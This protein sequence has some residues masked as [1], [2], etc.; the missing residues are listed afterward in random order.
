MN[1]KRPLILSLLVLSSLASAGPR[2]QV[3]F[4]GRPGT[5]PTPIPSPIPNDPWDR[6]DDWGRDNRR[7]R[8]ERIE[9]QVRQYFMGQANL[10][11][12][13]DYYILSQ[14]RFKKISRIEV[15]LSSERGGGQ[16][17]LVLNGRALEADRTIP[18]ELLAHS[19]AV[20]SR[21]SEI[22]RSLRSVVLELRGRFYVEKVTFITNE[23]DHSPIP[24]PFPPQSEILRQSI[25][26]RIQGE[27][28][29]NLFRQ[30]SL[31]EKQ[32]KQVSR[33]TVRAR[34]ARG[35]GEVALLKNVETFGQTQ[36]IGAYSTE[37]SFQLN[38][39]KIGL[40]LQSLR[41]QF[42]GDV[43]I[44][45]VSIEVGEGRVGPGPGP[46]PPMER[47]IEQ[48]V[49]QRLYD[50]SGVEL[51]RLMFVDRRHEERQ[52][53][54]VELVLR[55]AD[56]GTRVKLCTTLQRGPSTEVVCDM[57]QTLNQ[58]SQV[59]RLSASQFARLKDIS[60]S[61]RMGMIDIDR[62]IVQLR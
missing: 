10:N 5:N 24:G 45:E 58:G 13:S 8:E 32:G 46:F 26:Q 22:E 50:T 33:V 41:L 4:P 25:N 43:L 53:E 15:T 18:R 38:G 9:S 60:L 20:D 61:V 31:L 28:G 55:N 19:F 42:R 40:D 35:F 14:L 56:M 12:L 21:E 30:F 27:G 59:V 2:D 29:L 47:R 57:A 16:A 36:R 23:N 11:L 17:R 37:V 44:E 62:I 52:V 48:T 1:L 39:E 34:D 54:S 6:R 49:N 3:G 51:T 7:G